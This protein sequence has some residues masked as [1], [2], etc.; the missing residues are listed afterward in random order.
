LKNELGLF[1]RLHVKLKDF[2]IALNLVE[3]PWSTISKCFFYGLTNS[4]DS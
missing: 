4:K 1:R 3:I 2:F